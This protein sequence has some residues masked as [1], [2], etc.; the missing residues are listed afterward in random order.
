MYVLESSSGLVKIGITNKLNRRI[1]E[2][3]T[4]SG[5]KT[6]NIWST[7]Y[8]KLVRKTEYIAHDILKDCREQGE[9]FSVDF[10]EAAELVSYISSKIANLPFDSN[11]RPHI[12]IKHYPYYLNKISAHKRPMNKFLLENYKPSLKNRLKVIYEAI[13]LGF[14]AAMFFLFF[15]A[16]HD[17]TAYLYL[18]IS[19]IFSYFL[20][21]HKSRCQKKFVKY[22]EEKRQEHEQHEKKTL[23]KFQSPIIT[24][25]SRL[26]NRQRNKYLYEVIEKF[27]GIEID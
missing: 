17:E 16:V 12:D 20:M 14:G 7:A 18:C 5:Y 23:A 11:L 13:G 22:I 10:S 3:E 24:I 15:Y 27:K 26:L 1:R 6:T 25:D 19:I 8:H 9:W 2:I 4:A 21:T